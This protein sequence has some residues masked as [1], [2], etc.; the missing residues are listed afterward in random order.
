MDCCPVCNKIVDMDV[1]KVG[2]DCVN[3][4]SDGAGRCRVSDVRMI[5]E[6]LLPFRDAIVRRHNGYSPAIDMPEPKSPEWAIS[7]LMEEH[8][9]IEGAYVEQT[10]RDVLR[11]CDVDGDVRGALTLLRNFAK[12]QY[13]VEHL[14]LW[15]KKYATIRDMLEDRR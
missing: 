9:E 2:T 14:H 10:I 4:I 11:I 8:A 7:E 6:R 3:E 1:H 12:E 13:G 15:G 5:V